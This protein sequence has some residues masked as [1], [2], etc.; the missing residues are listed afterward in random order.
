LGLQS[1]YLLCA[2]NIYQIKKNIFIFSILLL[3]SKP[4]IFA[5]NAQGIIGVSTEFGSHYRRIGFK[6]GAWYPY[7]QIQ[8]NTLAHFFYNAK[9]IGAPGKFWE[10][11]VSASAIVAFGASNKLVFNSAF[12]NEQFSA[13]QKDWKISYAYKMYFD[14]RGTTQ[15]IGNIHLQYKNI[16]LHVL[17]DGFAFTPFDE[18]RTGSFQMH[19]TDSMI[20]I[21]ANIM[22]WTG[23][24]KNPIAIEDTNTNYGSID[25]SKN[26]FGKYSAGLAYLSGAVALPYQQ[27]MFVQVGVDDEHVR[28]LF[29]NKLV[30][31]SK[32]V[33]KLLPTINDKQLPMLDANGFG[34]LDKKKQKIKPKKF[35]WQVGVGEL[36]GY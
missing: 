26:K 2:Y 34:V 20:N 1:I 22:L 18:Y 16:S 11:Q 23:A 8:C 21:G 5:Q 7:K 29:Q 25:I 6:I 32:W 36:I 30:H 35:Y 3:L 19:Y 15:Q 33:H 17:N 27:N 14:T 31:N 4:Y 12:Y 28:H 10:M 9:S 24:T 13:L